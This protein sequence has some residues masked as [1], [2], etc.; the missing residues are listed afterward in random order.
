[1][2][3]D[4]KNEIEKITPE[5]I[6]AGADELDGSVCRDIWDGYLS[7]EIVAERI[8]RAMHRKRLSRP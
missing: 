7:R 1:M 4:E 2:E 5:M 8:Y 6:E 3:K